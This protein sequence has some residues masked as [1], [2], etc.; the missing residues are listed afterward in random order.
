MRRVVPKIAVER[1][2]D[3]DNVYIYIVCDYHSDW[4]IP[5]VALHSALFSSI[6][7][8]ASHD[9]KFIPVTQAAPRFISLWKESYMKPLEVDKDR[10]Q[11]CMSFNHA[12]I[13]RVIKT[14]KKKL[15]SLHQKKLKILVEIDLFPKYSAVPVTVSGFEHPVYSL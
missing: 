1:I 2:L 7:L 6:S 5:L 11:N 8:F 4:F 10:L 3:S 15:W 12:L 9:R 14:G 13:K